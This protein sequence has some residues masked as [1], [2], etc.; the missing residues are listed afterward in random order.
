[1]FSTV[2]IIQCP[3]PLPPPCVTTLITNGT[4]GCMRWMV[5]GVGEIEF[6]DK[7]IVLQN[8]GRT[9]AGEGARIL[10]NHRR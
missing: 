2:F 1:M 8:Y 4:S 9:G 7:M 6:I 5:D 10:Q 3:T